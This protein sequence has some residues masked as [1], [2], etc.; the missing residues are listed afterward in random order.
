MCMKQRRLVAEEKASDVET[1]NAA[2]KEASRA[3]SNTIDVKVEEIPPEP[4]QE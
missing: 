2:D 3:K 1:G 4:I